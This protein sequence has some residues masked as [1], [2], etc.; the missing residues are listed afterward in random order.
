M[1]VARKEAYVSGFPTRPQAVAEILG[2]INDL[3]RAD[4]DWRHGRLFSAQYHDDRELETVIEAA[5]ATSFW[6]NALSSEGFPS[7]AT[8]EAEVVGY[9]ADLLGFPDGTG[10]MTS[11]GSESIFQ[12]VKVAR[13]EAR[14]TKPQIK[15]PEVVLPA[16]AHP[17]WTK[18]SQYLGVQTIRVPVDEAH[19]ADVEAI[20]EA[21]TANT[22]LIVGSAMAWPHGVVDPIAALGK[23]ASD[24]GVRLHVD[25]CV[26]GFV[27]PFA[28]R[29][30]REV[31][32]F[33]LSVP[34]VSSISA[35]LHKFGYAP[36]GASL[37]LF[38]DPKSLDF[39]RFDFDDWTGGHYT[40]LTFSGSRP[41]GPIAAA[42][43]AIRYLAEPGYLRMTKSCLDA[44]DAFR[45]AI[46]QVGDFRV[47]GEPK[48]NL[49]AFASPTLNA[50][51]VN[52]GMADRGWLIGAQGKPASSLHLMLTPLHVNR[53]Q[54]FASDLRETVAS[55]GRGE[56]QLSEDDEVARYN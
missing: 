43:A 42:W 31:P 22:I 10:I 33:D 44:A 39:Q 47:V 36:K 5:V 38:R 24:R 7:L 15:S 53:E 56:V 26:G 16:S 3:Q 30:G 8:M 21:C 12:A 50:A 29:L 9:G 55:I 1:W 49:F 51:L 13:D 40:T 34:G 46:E 32:A 18:M 20:A 11:G 19:K 48:Y 54:E 28:R 27:L 17:A 23:L 2:R 41:G 35:D 37:V 6:L 14:Q 45:S 25:A 4:K 52:K